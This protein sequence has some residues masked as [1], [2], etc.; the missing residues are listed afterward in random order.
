MKVFFSGGENSVNMHLVGMT[1][2]EAVELNKIY[3]NKNK[4][5]KVEKECFK[6]RLCRFQIDEDVIIKEE[7]EVEKSVHNLD[8]YLSWR[9]NIVKGTRLQ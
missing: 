9:G 5:I 1:V 2:K 7:K 3:N 4:I 6:E 8:E